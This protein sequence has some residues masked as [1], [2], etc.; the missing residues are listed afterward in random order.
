[1]IHNIN[2]KP[3]ITAL[4]DDFK[5]HPRRSQKE[6]NARNAARDAGLKIV[7]DDDGLIIENHTI[8]GF[9]VLEGA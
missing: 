7:G 2:R 1:M 8:N 6:I 5:P 9:E 4:N 3:K